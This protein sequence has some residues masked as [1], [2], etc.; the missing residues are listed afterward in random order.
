MSSSPRRSCGS[1][2][3]RATPATTRAP[4]RRSSARSRSTRT[5]TVRCAPRPG[6][7]SACTTS[8]ARWPWRSAPGRSSP[9]TGGTT[10]RWPT[11]M[12]SWATTRARS[13]PRN[14]WSTCGP[15]CPRTPG[16][17]SCAHSSAT[18]RARRRRPAGRGGR[19]L[20]ACRGA[21][22]RAR[23]GSRAGRR[24]RRR[25]PCRR[26]RAPVRARRVH[27]QGRR[28]RRDDLRAPARP[29]L[30][31]PRPPPGG[32]AAPRAARGRRPG[33]HLHRRHPRLGLLQERPPGRSG[34]GRPPRA[35]ARHRG[36]DAPLPRRRHCRRARPRAD[37]GASPAPRARP[38][39]ALRSSPG[40]AGARG[41][42]RA[43]AARARRAR[44]GTMRPGL[45]A[46]ALA[47]PA[48]AAAHPLGNFSVNRYA[49]L[50]VEARMLSVRYVV[51]MAEIPAYQEIAALDRNRNGALDPEER[52]A[53][54][55]R[56][57]GALARELA[58]TV[59]GT[60]VPLAP[61]AQSLELPAGAGGL[62]TLRLEVC[63]TAPLPEHPGAL[64]FRD[65]NFAGRAG[66]REVVADAG[67]G[68][69]LADS[70]VPRVDRSQ[71][72]RAYPAD[73]LQSP[74]QVS[75]AR[76]R[77]TSGS[78]APLAAA[79]PAGA[80]VGAKRFGDRMTELVST[81]EPLGLGLVLTSLLVAALLGALH[82]LGPG[83]G[84]TIV[85]AYLIGTRGTARHALFLGLVV[86]ATHTLGVYLL[87]FAT[88][89]ASAWVVPE[90]LFPWISVLSGLLV[91]GIGASLVRSRLEVA[92]GEHADPHHHHDH[93]HGHSHLPPDV[94]G[95]RGLLALGV[96]GGLLP[97]PSAPVVMLAAIS[98]GRIGFGLVLIVAFSAG[99]AGVLGAI[100]LVFVYARSWFARLPVEGRFARYVPVASALVISAAGLLIVANALSQMGLLGVGL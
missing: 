79:T 41:A 64:E 93:D 62:P 55:G 84:K 33:R 57:P 90:R 44:R 4:T 13:R 78:A 96:S 45:A 37:R 68:L 39:P 6:C 11:P 14:A 36:R 74:P 40:A 85:G 89:G 18:G 25:R 19:P 72:L 73:L 69:A 60:A 3:S 48:V 92:L 7:C 82:A 29:L 81:R 15:V 100:G 50:R 61:R 31:R 65:R 66:W 76:F 28:G 23:P 24:P 27:G 54:L 1:R 35:P 71:A 30:R 5:T 94:L 56:A 34:A 97:R 95:W 2:A 42:G 17:R 21:R 98:L 88:W 63:L 20:P 70:S 47:L 86:T 38:E 52:D 87:G 67:A 51:D 8:A 59:D 10:A 75:E 77:I 26:G 58:L 12:S 32:G 46:L 80:L 53:Y 22:A 49:A 83:H 99:L 16:P 91:I 43:R 9:R